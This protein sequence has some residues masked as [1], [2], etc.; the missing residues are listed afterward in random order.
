MKAMDLMRKNHKA[1]SYKARRALRLFYANEYF[2]RVTMWCDEILSR[3]I[4]TSDVLYYPLVVAIYTVY[5]RPFTDCDGIGSLNESIVPEKYRD[6]HKELKRLRHELYA[7]SS[8]EGS[9][10]ITVQAYLLLAKKTEELI[11]G[12]TFYNVEISGNEVFPTHSRIREIRT[13]AKELQHFIATEM[14][15]VLEEVTK[16]I[17]NRVGCYILTTAESAGRYF[18]RAKTSG[19]IKVCENA[20]NAK[21][22]AP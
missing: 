8:A 5:T 20:F 16:E 22:K 7:H 10:P 19:E 12:Q 18:R 15:P 21:L 11:N 2:K 3:P 6:L 14:N 9:H 1:R 13:L 17:E 4:Q